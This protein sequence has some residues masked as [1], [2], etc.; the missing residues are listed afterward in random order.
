LKQWD[1]TAEG[2]SPLLAVFQS[3][4]DKVRP[5]MDYRE[6]NNYVESHTGDDKVAV[7]GEKIRKWRQLKG[8]LQ[9]VDLKS[10]YLQIH[11]AKDLWKYQVVRHKGVHYALIR[12]SFGLSCA[13]R[14]MASILGKVLSMDEWVRRATDHYIDDIVVQESVVG[15]EEVG[16][17]LAKYGLETKEPESL[18][19]GRLLGIALKSDSCGELWMM[20]ATALSEIHLEPKS[21]TKCG[22]FSLC[23]QLI[24]HYSVAGWLRMHCSFLRQL[25][26]DGG[27]DAPVER[28][29]AIWL[30]S[31]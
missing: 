14:I 28:L 17:Y 4:K 11:I 10:T 3:T 13:S 22:L 31:C 12:F 27:W 1:G 8:N 26:C 29:L 18:D 21:L 7:C 2:V 9:V 20:R 16:K 6:L 15:A 24:G 19:G 30:Q 25:G 23:G 5:V